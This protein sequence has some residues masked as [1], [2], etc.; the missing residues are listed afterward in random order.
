[1]RLGLDETYARETD[2]IDDMK[3]Q[4]Q[5]FQSANSTQ[6]PDLDNHS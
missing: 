1:M 6:R 2:S 4:K 3:M 5:W